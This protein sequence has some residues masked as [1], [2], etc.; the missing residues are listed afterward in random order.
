M[1]KILFIVFIIL[2]SS[3][4]YAETDEPFDISFAGR[5]LHLKSGIR[6][7][8]DFNAIS[9]APVAS[10]TAGKYIMTEASENITTEGGDQ[11]VTD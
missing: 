5:G 7:Q 3:S 10:S 11:L 4:A 2:I 9:S 1:K 8:I 6:N